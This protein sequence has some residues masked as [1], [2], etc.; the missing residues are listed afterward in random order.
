MDKVCFIF[1]M[2]GTLLNDL[3]AMHSIVCKVFE[4][5]GKKGPSLPEYRRFAGYHEYWPL[6]K[7]QGFK[8]S[9]KNKINK[10][11]RKIFNSEYPMLA[12][13]FGDAQATIKKF[14]KM[15]CSVGIVSNQGKKS[16]DYKIGLCG[17]AN[18]IDVGI[19]RDDVKMTKP[20]PESLILAFEK[21]GISAKDGIYVGDQAVDV[22]MARNAG[23]FSVAVSRSGSYDTKNMIKNSKPD[24]IIAKLSSLLKL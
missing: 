21:L 22:K 11:F 9:D 10:T 1:D 7:K 2:N 13:P 24:R 19:S 23:T 17:L 16:L 8:N 4:S 12:K 6:Y 15:D 3:A 14:R 18:L 20:K 5:F